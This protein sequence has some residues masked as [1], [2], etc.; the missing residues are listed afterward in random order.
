MRVSGVFAKSAITRLECRG[1]DG[2][3]FEVD[4]PKDAP[5]AGFAVGEAARLRA[6]RVFVFPEAP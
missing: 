2:T 6:R 3:A 1:E 5:E 4:F